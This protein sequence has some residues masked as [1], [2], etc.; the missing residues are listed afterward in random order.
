MFQAQ[1]HLLFDHN[2]MGI[3]GQNHT[4][5]LDSWLMETIKDNRISIVV[6]S[7]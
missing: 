6:L 1:L 3:L 7:H 2:H 5:F 4:I